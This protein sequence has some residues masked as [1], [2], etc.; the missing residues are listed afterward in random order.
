LCVAF[1][2]PVSLIRNTLSGGEKVR[3]KIKNKCLAVSLL[4]YL[5]CV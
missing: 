4:A 2:V 1:H 3:Q 5:N